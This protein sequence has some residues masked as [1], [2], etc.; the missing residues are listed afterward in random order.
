MLEDEF[1]EL[2]L[3]EN[4]LNVPLNSESYLR[5]GF[6]PERNVTHDISPIDTGKETANTVSDV[7]FVKVTSP[8]KVGEGISS[9]IVYRVNTK[10][11]GKE[12]SVLR[13]FSDFLGL[14]E[15]LVTKYLSEGVIV[16]P[17]PSKDMLATTKVKM[18]KDV[19][20]ENEFVE[21]RRI[22]LER[23]LSRVLSHPVLHIDEDVCDFLRHEGELPR[24]TNTQLLSGA[25]A[26]K[27][28]KNL[29]D[30]IGKFA[31]KVDDPEE[32]TAE[33]FFYQKADELDS[34]EKQ[35]KRLHSSLLNLVSG[36]NDLANAEA[37]LSRSVLLLA[38]V[39]ENTGLAQALH[40]LAET[41]G[42]VA[43]LHALQAEAHTCHLVEYSRELLGMVQACKDVLSERVRIYRTW[44]TAEANLR[45]KREQKIRM[46]M[47]PRNDN[48]KM[49]TITMELEDLENRVDQ[50]QHKFNNISIN[51][52]REFQNFDL[53]R[54][55]YFKQA[56]TE[57]LELLLQIQLKVLENWEKYLSYTNS[58]N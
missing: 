10:F 57:Y 33:E 27:V 16:P 7:P 51:I 17:V 23:F 53:N 48:K 43:D 5:T 14:H 24:A 37:G 34:W 4:S 2:D 55:A 20:A 15:R 49:A 19:S 12:F 39:E 29:G 28:M 46:E 22:A 21:R 44:K 8:A 9:Y 50:A 56:T 52:K 41:E 47:A 11:N 45:S 35:L 13:R 38:N 6:T 31:Y 32:N 58:I 54:F 36:D 25:A 3:N 42:H 18:S 26:I 30:A 1:A 40:H